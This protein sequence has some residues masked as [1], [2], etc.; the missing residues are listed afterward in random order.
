M[1]VSRKQIPKIILLAVVTLSTISLVEATLNN[2]R[3]Y[4]ALTNF[5]LQVIGIDF[6]TNHESLNV[7]INLKV[8]NPTSYDRLQLEH[9]SGTAYYEGEPHTIVISPGKTI[10]GGTPYQEIETRWGERATVGMSIERP[11]LPYSVTNISMN[12]N[13]KSETAK[14][15]TEYFDKQGR[16]QE[17]I[18][19]QLNLIVFLDTPTFLNMISLE[20]EF[21]L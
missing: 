6:V 20:Y 1:H 17:D 21:N 19:W 12:L 11:I 5:E 13:A 18:R 8:S 15:F 4:H 14:I 9:I 16:H 2:V 7:A 10:L 3:F